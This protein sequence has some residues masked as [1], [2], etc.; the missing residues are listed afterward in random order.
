MKMEK[1]CSY[2]MSVK[3]K[4]AEVRIFMTIVV[5]TSNLAILA[6]IPTI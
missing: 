4:N 3:F 5:R 2:K 1:E 6:G